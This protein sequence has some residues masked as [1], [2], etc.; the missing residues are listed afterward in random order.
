MKSPIKDLP[1]N[2]VDS[3]KTSRKVEWGGMNVSVYEIHQTLDCAPLCKGLL[4][5]Q[6]QVP[7]WGFI[8]EGQMRCKFSDR[9]EVYSAGD[10]FYHPPGHTTVWESGLVYI[11]FT[12]TDEHKKQSEILQN[13]IQESN[14]E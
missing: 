5:D 13:I 12:P 4:N 8:L 9:E 1:V 6:C 7:H 14:S 11:A 2:K 10:V 3:Q